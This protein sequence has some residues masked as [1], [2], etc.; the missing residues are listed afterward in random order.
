MLEAIRVNR[1]CAFCDKREWQ[2]EYLI[3][4]P[5]VYIC[6]ECVVWSHGLLVRRRSATEGG[7]NSSRV[8]QGL[9]R[10]E[11]RYAYEVLRTHFAPLTSDALVTA[12]RVFPARMR[13]DLQ[14]ALDR[15]LVAGGEQSFHGLH[16]R[17][18]F[19]TVV[20]SALLQSTN[21][22]ISLAPPHY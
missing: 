16:Y 8:I 15:H 3:E 2:V 7:E 11:R 14:R 6:D 19:E 13:A 22:P 12:T 18:A 1:S 10:H 9:A 4:G 5:S 20:F 21:E 17:H